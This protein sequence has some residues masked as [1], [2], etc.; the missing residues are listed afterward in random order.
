MRNEKDECN[1]RRRDPPDQD[2]VVQLTQA[3]HQ[4][5]LQSRE[6]CKV[7]QAFHADD[8]KL[9]LTS[10]HSPAEGDRGTAPCRDLAERTGS[11]GRGR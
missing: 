5:T 4:Q 8:H 10:V 1:K 3:F 11:K 7:Q 2:A 9:G 6:S